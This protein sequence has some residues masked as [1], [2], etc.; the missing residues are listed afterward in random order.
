M[1]SKVLIA[2][3][4]LIL[5]G[6]T[7]CPASAG[8]ISDFPTSAPPPVAAELK[9][10]AAARSL[11]FGT[12]V[13]QAF[14]K[15]DSRYIDILKGNCNIVV[16]EN[17]M[18]FRYLQPERGVYRF[19]KAD[20][21]VEFA[22]ANGMKVRGH[23]L[24]WHNENPAWLQDGKF[25]KNQLLSLL[26]DH[27]R[28]VMG[29]YKGRILEWDVVNETVKHPSFWTRK[30]GQE[31]VDSAFVYAH[32]AD[33][34]ALLFYNDYDAENNSGKGDEVFE[35]VLERRARGIPIHGVGLQGHFMLGRIDSA[36]IDRNVKRLAAA[37]LRVS[38]TE[39]DVRMSLPA[40]SAKLKQQARDYATVLGICLDNSNCR[41]FLTWGVH[42][43][44]SWI[45][46]AHPGRGAALPYDSA[47]APKPAYFALKK[48]LQGTSSTSVTPARKASPRPAAQKNRRSGARPQIPL[49]QGRKGNG[50][51]R[52]PSVS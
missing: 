21:L 11:H 22:E 13:G 15:G 19:A 20:S 4:A 10:L 16:A 51:K 40:D 48:A 14:Y 7:T 24:L 23:T 29:R 27:I 41:T 42:D 30:V 39:V 12:A 35:Y 47:F 5:G 34:A 37:G 44:Q 6:R 28:T 2:V 25:D 26:E 3:S 33:P 1:K 8:G 45:P 18:K 9:P 50:A 43:G 38:F 17:H 49:F 46:Q 36:S 32:R 31:A 52:A